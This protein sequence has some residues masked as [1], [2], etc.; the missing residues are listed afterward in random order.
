MIGL[1]PPSGE[2]LGLW[3]TGEP[4]QALGAQGGHGGTGPDAKNSAASARSL[5]LDDS[6]DVAAALAD[7]VTADMLCTG[8]PKSRPRSLSVTTLRLAGVV[9][10]LPLWAPATD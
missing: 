7:G 9:G 5:E 1:C 4:G 6:G 2:R 8:P 3:H 10:T